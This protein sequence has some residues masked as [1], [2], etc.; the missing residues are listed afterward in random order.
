[1]ANFVDSSGFPVGAP[2]IDYE[3]TE[4]RADLETL[5]EDA[6]YFFET[7]SG[8]PPIEDLVLAFGVSPILA[9]FLVRHADPI[10]SGERAGDV[11]SWVVVG[12]LPF[13][14][15]ETDE[16][17]TPVVALELYCAIAQDWAERV[18]GDGDLSESYPIPVKP[19]EGNANLLLSR[20]EFIREK[21]I[22]L[23][24]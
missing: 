15:F 5:R 24:A 10:Q 22:P 20:I 23:A 14:L 21:L 19:T 18:L 16:A 11:E 9:L 2:D 4:E 12:D 3:S 8:S 17:P 13:M 7:R 6:R 1:M